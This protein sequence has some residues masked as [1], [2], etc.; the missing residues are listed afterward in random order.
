MFCM[1]CGT[2]LPDNAKFCFNCGE[3]INVSSQL[4][5]VNRISEEVS[6]QKEEVIILPFTIDGISVKLT[7][8]VYDNIKYR[9]PF[10]KNGF[11]DKKTILK[12]FIENVTKFDD[13]FSLGIPKCLDCIQL[14]VKLAVEKLIKYNIFEYDID[15]FVIQSGIV[16]EFFNDIKIVIKK[17]DEIS[18]YADGLTYKRD[19]Q[20]ASRSHWEGGGFGLGGAIKGSLTAGIL[21][22]GTDL[23]RGIGDS[24]TN[25]RDASKIQKVKRDA[26]NSGNYQDLIAIAVFNASE[27][28][29]HYFCKILKNKGILFNDIPLVD[30]YIL[31]TKLDNLEKKLRNNA[32]S[33]KDA[34]DIVIEWFERNPFSAFYYDFLYRVL[35]LDNL[36]V[37]NLSQYFG[38]DSEFE[39]MKLAYVKKGINKLELLQENKICMDEINE[40]KRISGDCNVSQ[41]DINRLGE[42]E[43]K[44]SSY[45][46]T[47]AA[48][49][50]GIK[51]NSYKE[52]KI[53]EFLK[54]KNINDIWEIIIR[55]EDNA[56][57]EWIL[58]DY[59]SD[60]V[61]SDVRKSD[62]DGID[63]K[64]KIVYQKVDEHND[65]AIFLV[66][67]I[68]RKC[69]VRNNNSNKII[70][71]D[72]KIEQL[73]ENGQ[74]SAC[75]LVGFFYYKGDKYF[76][77]D[78]NKAFTFLKYAAEKNHPTAM[79]WLG[80][81]YLEGL[82]TNQDKYEAKKW[83]KIAAYYGHNYA[84]D[85]LK[86]I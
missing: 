55:D 16:D 29:G 85:E 77:K 32:I 74:V 84:K 30:N 72:E 39:T 42:L 66:N 36:E 45:D 22:A 59:Y 33:K 54:N 50:V 60:L 31:R 23:F 76:K 37:S 25:S 52:A 62:F 4:N 11:C 80:T 28:T 75:A 24:I 18:A 73:A 9:V 47:E 12:F 83:L 6:M 43:Y 67:Y 48:V 3:K 5:R 82:G 21:N 26:Y 70:R 63:T 58:M 13:L 46:K 56:Y 14:S 79:A 81:C 15:S 2:E 61:E 69:Y 65:F 68:K 7:K 10:I 34:R 40:L 53:R 27:R 86:K 19:I 1:E 38:C 35:K 20:K 51:S 8:S 64:L 41:V 44:K 17:F 78:Y 71:S 57:A 49:A